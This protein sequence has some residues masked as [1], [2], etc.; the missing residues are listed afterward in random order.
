MWF[1][2]QV[3]EWLRIFVISPGKLTAK[4]INTFDLE[5]SVPCLSLRFVRP[6]TVDLVEDGVGV[7]EADAGQDNVEEEEDDGK[8]GVRS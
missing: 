8:N 2:G 4:V 6:K 3:G 5:R 1:H 7:E